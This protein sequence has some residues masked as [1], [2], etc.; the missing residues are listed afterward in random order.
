MDAFGRFRHAQRGH[1][2]RHTFGH[3]YLYRTKYC[4]LVHTRKEVTI[5]IQAC[6]PETDP[7][8]G[9]VSL[10]ETHRL[11]RDI[12]AATTNGTLYKP[13]MPLPFTCTITRQ[14]F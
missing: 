6:S 3:H 7:V 14:R 12:V 1:Y 5:F 11:R 13:K 9:T 8:V 2:H 4:R 10:N